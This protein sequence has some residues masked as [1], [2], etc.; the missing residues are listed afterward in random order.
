[1]SADRAVSETIGFV[2]VFA[3]VTASVGVVYTAGIGGLADAR[4]D[5]QLTNAVRAFDVLADNVDDVAESGAPSRATELKLKDSTLRYGEQIRIAVQVN[6]TASD[7]NAS[8]ATTTRPLVYDAPAGEVVFAGGATF[9]VDDGNAA[10]RAEPGFVVGD[11]ESNVSMIPLL[12][13]YPRGSGGGIGGSSTVL[14]VAY[15]KSAGHATPFETGLDPDASDARV[16]VTVESPRADAWG[17]YFETRGMERVAAESGDGKVTY[18]FYTDRLVV[19]ELIVE[20]DLK[21]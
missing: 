16:N 18:Q 13:V 3:L 5:E 20:L 19:P 12:T 15:R 14:V 4:E 9:R 1:M 6:D 10:M 17:W 8:Y 7:A 21:R 2:F 11:G